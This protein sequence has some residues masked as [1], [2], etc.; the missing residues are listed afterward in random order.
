MPAKKATVRRRFFL[1]A[2]LII[3]VL[4]AGYLV[5]SLISFSP[6]DPIWSQTAWH[7]P[8]HN[9]GG[10]VEA[11]LADMLFFIFGIVAY[12][13]PLLGVTFCQIVLLH[14]KKSNEPFDYF[15]I[16]LRLIGS[17]ALVLSACSLATLSIHDLYYFPSGGVIGSLFGNMM[18]LNFNNTAG[19]VCI[20]FIWGA[21]LTLF[22]GWSWLLIAEKIGWVVL[23]GLHFI[24]D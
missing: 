7:E 19:T 17:L 6:S 1:E 14:K 8:I 5:V 18:L 4:F 22:T 16:S 12:V 24:F 20:L 3:M 15:F 21:D 23:N 9:L 2:W 11:W 10:G 13:I